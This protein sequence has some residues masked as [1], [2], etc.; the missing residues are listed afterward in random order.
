VQGDGQFS[1]RKTTAYKKGGSVLQPARAS[2]ESQPK[3]LMPNKSISL[4]N[5]A[6]TKP[7]TT[8]S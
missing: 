3:S 5:G 8:V 1:Q 2:T 7:K 6:K 4:T